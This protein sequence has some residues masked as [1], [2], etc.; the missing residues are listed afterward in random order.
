MW[1]S[2][3][4]FGLD[5][6]P[7]Q[8][9]RTPGVIAVRAGGDACELSRTSAPAGSI[10]F[11]VT[12]EGDKITEFYLYSPQ[13]KVVSEVEGIGPGTSRSMTVKVAEAGSCITA[14]KP[15]MVG[16]GVRGQFAVTP[17]SAG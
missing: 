3:L 15:G 12:N 17:S 5:C 14:C 9:P 10:T 4:L 11:E 1:T 2:A 16:K 8:T 7:A 13:G 6:A